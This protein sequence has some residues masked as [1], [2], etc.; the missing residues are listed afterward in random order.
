MDL[1]K[2]H[3]KE[4]TKRSWIDKLPS[5]TVRWAMFTGVGLA[6][7]IVGSG[8]IA[9]TI[10]VSLSALDGFLLERLIKG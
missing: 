8:G 3:Y 9:T 5:K 10:G 4:V 6:V 7:D 2:A 1:T